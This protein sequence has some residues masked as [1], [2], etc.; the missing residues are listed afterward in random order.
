M[1]NKSLSGNNFQV[2]LQVRRLRDRQQAH[3]RSRLRLLPRRRV[4]LQRRI[5]RR[6]NRHRHNVP[7]H[8]RALQ[9]RDNDDDDDIENYV[10]NFD[11]P[12]CQDPVGLNRF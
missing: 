7:L 9:R 1:V 12:C 5:R 6:P 8:G 4:R 2:L 11:Q 3:R 10:D